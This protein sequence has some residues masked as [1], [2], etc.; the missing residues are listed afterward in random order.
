MQL[1]AAK[2]QTLDLSKH[3]KKMV[4]DER[5]PYGCDEASQR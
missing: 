5:A 4:D 2:T 1:D 3:L